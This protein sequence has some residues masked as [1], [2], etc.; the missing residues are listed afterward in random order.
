[1]NYILLIVLLIEL[2]I[3]YGFNGK[4]VV[5]PSFIA[6]GG[7]ILS[8]GV[9][10]LSRDFF[11]YTL[12]YT[13]VLIISFVIICIL[14]GELVASKFR[15]SMNTNLRVPTKSIDS[16][17]LILIPKFVILIL[18]LFVIAS[19]ILYLYDAYLFSLSVGNTPGNIFGIAKYVRFSGVDYSP[20]IFIS[21]SNLLSECIVYLV[22]Y[23]YSYNLILFK[24][25]RLHYLFPL[26]G[27]IPHIL[28][29]DGRTIIIKILSICILIYFTL[30]KQKNNWAKGNNRKIL[31]VGIMSLLAFLF[32]FRFLGYRTDSSINN[33]LWNNLSEYI[34][35]GLVGLDK[36]VLSGAEKSDIFGKNVLT[37]FYGT[38]RG[39]GLSVPLYSTNDIFFTYAG[40]E[41]NIY[42]GLKGYIADFTMIGL[43]ISMFMWGYCITS[44]KNKIRIGGVSIIKVFLLGLFFYPVIL[45]SIAGATHVVLSITT[46]YALIYLKTLE[47]LFIKSKLFKFS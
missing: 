22:F 18:F 31:V 15:F 36:Y 40:G 30:N 23:S 39:L 5:S 7:F 46:V 32:I 33:S 34:S 2:I 20:S 21:Q 19:G 41:S 28:S 43:F 3:V 13:S 16:K 12:T 24:K 8:T 26:L 29:Y 35:S 10:I 47:Y 1:M 4:N 44:L 37:A 17:R 42:T 6:T 11:Q 25:N 9:L 38:L 45:I 27:F 14:I